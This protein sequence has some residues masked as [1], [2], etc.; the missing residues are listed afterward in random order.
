MPMFDATG[1]PMTLEDPPAGAAWERVV[2]GFLAHSASTPDHLAQVLDQA[3]KAGGGAAGWVH[4]SE[5]MGLEG[6]A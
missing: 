2:S 5:Q 6:C 4:V 3:R 1:L